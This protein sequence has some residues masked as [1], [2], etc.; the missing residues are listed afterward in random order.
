MTDKQKRTIREMRRYGFT[1]LTIAE[2]LGL[3]VNTVKSFCFRAKTEI[4]V[5]NENLCKNCG[6]P[7]IRI[8]GAKPKTFCSDKCRYT[9]WNKVRSLQKQKVSNRL[10]CRD[11]AE[12][13]RNG[14]ELP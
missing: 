9:W 6:I 5:T 14:E 13:G 3:S 7:L 12:R 11:Y 8:A 10:I 1:Y 2:T 4:R